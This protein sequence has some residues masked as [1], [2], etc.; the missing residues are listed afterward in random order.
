LGLILAAGAAVRYLSLAERS[1][2]FDETLS[3]RLARFPLADVPRLLRTSQHPPLYFVLLHGWIGAFGD[4]ALALRSLSAAGGLAAVLGTYLFVRALLSGP[5]A[6]PAR[7][8]PQ[9]E[10]RWAALVSATLVA[11]SPLQIRYSWEARMYAL[12]AALAAFS[13]WALIHALDPDH[14]GWRWW[15]G[16]VVLTLASVYSHNFALLTVAAQALFVGGW[17]CERAGGRWW[18][19]GRS[20]ALR[21]AC[22]A[23]ASVG[24]GFL[25]W[26]PI[27][28]HQIS[29]PEGRSWIAPLTSEWQV[30]KAV[31]QIFVDPE[32]QPSRPASLR[33]ALLLGLIVLVTARRGRGAGGCV[34]TLGLAPI[35]L[36]VAACLCGVQVFHARY[37]VYPKGPGK[38]IEREALL[39]PD[40]IL[41]PGR[42][43]A[44]A[45]RRVWVVNATGGADAPLPECPPARGTGTT[46]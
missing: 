30:Y 38:W 19:A 32:S 18:A 7:T 14:R 20:P 17:V 44:W 6:G 34:L 31:Y 26:V 22:L 2:W 42:M 46:A 13:S 21:P 28:R 25:P 5:L 9:T 23:F 45:D 39:A 16:Y 12:G 4:S 15:L 29:H 36:T 8:A 33:V 24:V 40:E 35:G 37:Y 27:L 41:D 43:N 1:L 3:W 11:L 10:A